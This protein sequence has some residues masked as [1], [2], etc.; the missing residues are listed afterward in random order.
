VRDV[1]ETTAAEKDTRR[2]DP[3]VQVRPL[4]NG[5]SAREGDEQSAQ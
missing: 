1:D 3:L 5:K 4:L 2:L